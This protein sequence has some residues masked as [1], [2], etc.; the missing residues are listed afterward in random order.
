MKHLGL[1]EKENQEIVK[2]LKK[3]NTHD[4]ISDI[5][6]IPRSTITHRIRLYKLNELADER[7]V[8]AKKL[9]KKVVMEEKKKEKYIEPFYIENGRWQFRWGMRVVV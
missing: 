4:D 9:E 5:L 3:R 6:G 7:I 1:I 2:L 8:I